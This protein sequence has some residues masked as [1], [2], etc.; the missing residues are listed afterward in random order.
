[1]WPPRWPLWPKAINDFL[2]QEYLRI[3]GCGT[4]DAQEGIEI[5]SLRCINELSELSWPTIG[6]TFLARHFLNLFQLK[7]F[8]RIQSRHFTS[9]HLYFHCPQLCPPNG[10]LI[11]SVRSSSSFLS[12]LRSS[13]HWYQPIAS[14]SNT[15]TF[16]IHVTQRRRW[17]HP[18]HSDF[19]TFPLF[20]ILLSFFQCFIRSIHY[21]W[22]VEVQYSHTDR[23]HTHGLT[24]KK[25]TVSWSSD[26]SKPKNRNEFK[27]F[28]RF[29]KSSSE[30]KFIPM[31]FTVPFT[32][33]K[34]PRI[35]RNVS[36]GWWNVIQRWDSK[37]HNSCQTYCANNAGIKI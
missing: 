28:L 9:P 19:F 7:Y 14:A 32:A 3:K 29:H 1:M 33:P 36:F 35:D 24:G 8:F 30:T 2:Q 4:T 15:E 11:I 6:F 22:S 34:T 20:L 10:S 17:S 27:N 21:L 26:I 23:C 31:R 12:L 5:Q 13:Q 16:S 18:R 37:R 25:S